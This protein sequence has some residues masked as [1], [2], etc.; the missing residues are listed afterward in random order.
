MNK[1]RKITNVTKI[2]SDIVSSE[3]SGRIFWV[4]YLL[5]LVIHCIENTSVIYSDAVWVEGMYLFRNLLYLVLL[6]RLGMLAL[7]KRQELVCAG[8][9]FAVGAVSFLGSR[10]FGMMEFVLIML[11]AKDES[12]RRLVTAFAAIKVAAM[13]LTLLL[14]RVGVLAAVL[15]QDDNVGY[16]NTYGSCHRNVLAANITVLCLAWF[17]LRWR[18]LKIWDVAVWC[19]IALLTWPVAQS[20]TGLIILFLIIFGMFFGSRKREQILKVPD[21]RRIVLLFFTV[22]LLIS[23][24]GTLF[25]SDHSAVWKLIDSIFTKRFKFAHQCLEQYG[26]TLFGQQLPFVSTIEA[27][28]SDAARLILDNSYMRA[29][30]YYGL[31]PGGMF[32]G[33]YFRALDLSV[34]RKDVRLMICLAVFAVYGLSESYLLDVNYQFP[35]LAAWS[36]YFFPTGHVGRRARKSDMKSA[37][38]NHG[39]GQVRKTA[40]QYAGDIVRHFKGKR[41]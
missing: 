33:T 29:L 41:R 21:L 8:I 3:L 28:N 34:R 2:Y 4:S 36:R 18:S 10:D 38:E 7:Y 30:L 24:I 22:I 37:E 5:L 35:L 39:G 27:Q 40:L 1:L 11:S 13:I 26:L 12:P 20:R 15:Y 31:I 17:Y 32:L 25:Y 14:W 6:A 9:F 16:Y 19:A 23:V